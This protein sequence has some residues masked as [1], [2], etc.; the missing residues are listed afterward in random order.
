MNLVVTE[1]TSDV[2][3]LRW[4]TIS[5]ELREALTGK[6]A[7]LWGAEGDD[8]VFNALSGDK[9]QALIL[10]VSRLRAKGLWHLIKSI[11]NVYG[12]GGV[13]IQFNA[14][15]IMESLLLRRKDF[16]RR[17]ANHKNTSG[18]F[19]EKG[20]GDAVLHFLYVEETPRTWYVHFD[21]YSPVHST[22]S[23]FNHLRH[24]FCGKIRPDWRMIRERLNT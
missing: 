5:D 22:G 6:L 1:P 17:F 4:E 2:G 13:G 10:V 19:Y 20:R 15:P 24:E 16:T 11:S 9:Q 7:G 12:E 3:T 23:A 18:G 21:L 14:W 8:E